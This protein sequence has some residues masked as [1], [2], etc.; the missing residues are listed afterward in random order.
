ME[1]N[2]NLDLDQARTTFEYST[3]NIPT[4]GKDH[5]I[6]N[7]ISKTETFVKNIRWRAFFFLNPKITK[8]GKET[9]GFPSQ[10]PPPSLAELTEFEDE[11][12]ELVKNI[13]YK[14]TLCC[15][16]ISME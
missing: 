6:R 9:Y 3:K 4:Y 1:K 2:T 14:P 8:Q 16:P 12:A 10:T 15:L 13:K 5:Y 7:L 11:L